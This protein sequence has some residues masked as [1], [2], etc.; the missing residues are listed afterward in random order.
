[1]IR[2]VIVDDHAIVRTGLRQF[3]SEHVD[4]R[5]TGEA[6]DGKEVLELLRQGEVDVILMDLSMPGHGGVDALAAVKARAPDLPVLI[7]SGFPEAH[8]A[9][10]LLRQGA[11]G[12][13]NKECDPEEIVSAIRTVVRGRRYITPAVAELLADNLSGDADKPLHETLSERELQVFLRL[14]RGETVGHIADSMSLSVKTVSTYRTRV[15]E[16]MK[17]ASNSDLT[18]YALKNGLI[19]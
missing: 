19:Q 6:S 3:L 16:K 2:V 18:Y 15:M 14:A 7:L 12:Y 11:S 10:A 9:T 5:V 17:L 13:L 8:Y 4:L 1:M